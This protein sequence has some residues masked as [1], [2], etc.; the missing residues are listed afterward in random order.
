MITGNIG[1]WSELYTLLK[2]LAD[3]KLYS[4]DAD[5]NK[6]PDVWSPL[7][8]VFRNEIESENIE[9][10]LNNKKHEIEL[11]INGDKIKTVQSTWLNVAATEL[12]NGILAESSG[13]SSFAIPGSE[14]TMSEMHCSKIKAKSA[15]KSDIKMQIHDIN[16]GHN[17]ICGFSIKSDLGAAPTL[18]NA[19]MH[20]NFVYEVSGLSDDDIDDINAIETKTKIIDRIN[21]IKTRGGS[22]R[23]TKIDSDIFTQNV[24]Y[25]DSMMDDILGHLLLAYYCGQ[26]SDLS[27]VVTSVEASDPIGYHHH[28][29]Y[30]YKLKKF[31]SAIA[32]GMVPATP[33]DGRD[34]ANGG[35]IIVKNN[36]DIVAYQLYNRDSFE[37]Y[38]LNNTKFERASTKRYRYAFLYKDNEKIYIKLNM[39]IRFK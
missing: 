32:L 38:L 16:T 4:A 39:Q 9:Y 20:T 37:T 14:T 33:W 21:E 3:G 27:D 29:L 2:L 10:R 6:L 25:I 28:G 15:D 35:Y 19:S 22:F 13:A 18:F 30:R 17:R 12:Y 1:E 5:L 11:Y 8:R 36:G 34:E 31:L 26:M 23:Y 24:T 7:L